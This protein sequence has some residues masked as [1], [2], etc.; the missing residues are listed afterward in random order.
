MLRASLLPR[1]RIL[2]VVDSLSVGGIERNLIELV[3]QTRHEIEHVICCVRAGGPLAAP[4]AALGTRVHVVGTR[5]W[6][7]MPH[8]WRLCRATA[9]DALHARNW[10][11]IDAIFAARLARVPLVIYGEHG[12]GTWGGRRRD[13]VRRAVAAVADQ[14]VAV[15]N[16]VRD[17]F[18]RIGVR[19]SKIRVIANGVDP[20]R[21]RPR[22][23]RAELR[24]QR[25][26]AADA[27]VIGG[28]GRLHSLKN[29]DGLI[30]A[31]HELTRRHADAHLVLVG[32]GPERQRLQEAIRSRALEKR[33]WITGFRDDVA[34]WLAAMD[35]FA[36]PSLTEGASNVILQ[37]MATGLPVVATDLPAIR[38]LVLGDATGRLVAPGESAALVDALSFY[39]RD[40][41]ARSAHGAAGRRRVETAFPLE[42]MID[43][44]RTLYQQTAATRRA[45]SAG[46]APT[47]P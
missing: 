35:V 4:L 38:E 32:D 40:G 31:F 22:P 39:C 46:R 14:V 34:D 43:G 33:V 2:H 9:P 27:L 7:V 10:G 19:P 26:L 21:F 3:Q 25:G 15:S 47:G 5:P 12:P 36:H 44:Y 37:A 16:A 30:A 20:H 1:I 28:I 18:C 11:A 6:G 17:Y 41:A 23:D 42:R 13:W 45:G 24:R 8:L 29:Y